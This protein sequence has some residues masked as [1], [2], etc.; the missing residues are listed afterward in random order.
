MIS[1]SESDDDIPMVGILHILV[2]FSKFIL[3]NYSHQ[4]SEQLLVVMV[5]KMASLYRRAVEDVPVKV[6]SKERPVEKPIAKER[7]VDKEVAKVKEEP[8]KDIVKLKVK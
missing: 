1:D 6:T 8:V 4:R 2:N 3:I 5:N 7:P